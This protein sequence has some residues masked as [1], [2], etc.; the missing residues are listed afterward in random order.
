M[1]ARTA[2]RASTGLLQDNPLKSPARPVSRTPARLLR[3]VLV[4]PALATQATAETP[5]QE[6][7][8]RAQRA[9]TNL[10]QAMVIA[11]TAARAHTGILQDKPL[12]HPA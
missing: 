7:A 1:I 3:V 6:H 10:L 9:S 5:A 11:L 12:S 4:P 2:A 8:Q